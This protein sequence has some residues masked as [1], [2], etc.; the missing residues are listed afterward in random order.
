MRPTVVRVRLLSFGPWRSRVAQGGEWRELPAGAGVA[1]L[2]SALQAEGR[3]DAQALRSAAIAVNQEYARS[4]QVLVDG[5]E[6][7]ILP[8]VSGGAEPLVEITHGVIDTDAILREIKAGG[9]GAV[10]VFDGIVRNNT[11]GRQTLHLDYEAYEEMALKQMHTLRLEAIAKYG[12]REIAVVHRLGRL[13]VGE[14]SVLIAVASAHRGAAFDA[15]RWVIDTLK[16]TVPIWKH[17]QFVDG[18]V[19]SDG[20][21]FPEDIAGDPR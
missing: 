4:T 10:C 1:D 11:R 14:T 3:F 19:W 18:A 7:A 5:D 9:D 8:P 13:F 12:V 2:L 17:E 16:K 15:C 21:P 6:V 20:E